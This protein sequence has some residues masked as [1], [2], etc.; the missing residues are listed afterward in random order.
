ML[1]FATRFFLRL[2]IIVTGISLFVSR[3]W[4]WSEYSSPEL[5]VVYYQLLQGKTQYFVVNSD[6]S[7]PS[8]PLS[9]NEGGITSPDCSPDGRSFAF[10]SNSGHVYVMTSAGLAHD[11][12]EDQRY[13]TVNV[14]N[15]G[16]LALF[17]PEDSHLLINDRLIDLSTPDRAG[18]TFDRID[19][20]AQG[21]VLWTRDFANI[22]VVSLATGSIAP[23]VTHGYSGQWNTSGQMIVFSDQVTDAEGSWQFRGQY[24][25]DM[26]TRRIARIGDWILSSPL[27]PDSTQ[28]AASMPLAGF[29]HIAQ[30]AVFSVFNN[31][32]P[33]VLTHDTK[34]ASQPVC[35]LTFRPDLLVNGS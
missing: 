33:Q 24:L 8:E 13:T 9:W 7:S 19:I 4:G 3:A 6:G 34:I 17:D 26:A 12:P 18:N 21:L 14:A 31:R 11:S 20:S 2:L 16:T 28:V 15:D 30:V 5:Y 22:Q 27:S 35:F 25:M 29:N 32:Q 10:L 1:R 23:Y